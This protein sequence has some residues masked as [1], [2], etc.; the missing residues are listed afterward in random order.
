MIIG[1]GDFA[2]ASLTLV[3]THTFTH[4]HI[5]FYHFG[6]S[7]KIHYMASVVFQASIVTKRTLG[8]VQMYIF[9][10]IYCYPS[11]IRSK[12]IFIASFALV[13]NCSQTV[14]SQP[15]T[16]ELFGFSFSL[17]LAR[18]ASTIILYVYTSIETAIMDSKHV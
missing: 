12:L 16:S 18:F 4:T 7:Y 15:N 6:Y 2:F 8:L 11:N 13:L 10:S 17:S 9:T 14:A 1:P 3:H 5:Y